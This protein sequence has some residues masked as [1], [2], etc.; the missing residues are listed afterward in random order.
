MNFISRPG[1]MRGTGRPHPLGWGAIN[2]PGKNHIVAVA[3]FND[4]IDQVIL[5]TF[6]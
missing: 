6:V 5:D 1:V 2:S 3:H 4:G